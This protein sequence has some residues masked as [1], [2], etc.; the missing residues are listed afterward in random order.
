MLKMLK[1]LTGA[2]SVEIRFRIND[3]VVFESP[4]EMMY[5]AAKYGGGIGD[6]GWWDVLNADGFSTAIVNAPARVRLEFKPV[7]LEVEKRMFRFWLYFVLYF[8]AGM[9]SGGALGWA[10]FS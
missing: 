5:Y 4:A 1:R 9:V 3:D 2:P 7:R 6:D 8:I 10:V